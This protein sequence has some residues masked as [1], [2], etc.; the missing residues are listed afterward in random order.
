MI[1]HFP[2]FDFR[3]VALN[4]NG[5]PVG[6][7]DHVA[8]ARLQRQRADQVAGPDEHHDRVR[9]H[10]QVGDLLR[11]VDP[12]RVV[13]LRVPDVAG[14]ARKRDRAR[15]FRGKLR[16]RG[17]GNAGSTIAPLAGHTTW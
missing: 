10:Q 16:D 11:A 8:V 13:E 17:T 9:R 14:G 6:A 12:A 5:V 3:I 7:A 4:L 2:Q 1:D 15:R